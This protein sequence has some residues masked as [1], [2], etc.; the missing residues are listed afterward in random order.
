[1]P[2]NRGYNDGGEPTE[3]RGTQTGLSVAGM[4]LTEHDEVIE[5][6]VADGADEALC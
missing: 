4:A 2:F 6:L 5:A 3:S 1:M